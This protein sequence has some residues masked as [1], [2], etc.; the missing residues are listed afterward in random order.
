MRIVTSM[1][2]WVLG[3]VSVVLKILGIS[4]TVFE[5]TK[6]D[7]STSSSSSNDTD[8]D[9]GRFTFNK[10]PIFVPVTTLLLVQ[11]MALAMVILGMQPRARGGHGSGI[12]DVL[13]SAWLVLCLW[14]VLKGLFGKG[15]YGIPL[16]TLCKST[17]LALLFVFWCRRTT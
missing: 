4:E 13:C 12:L 16:S 8:G 17:A 1:S 14:P 3:V 10:S 11:L 7:Q 15:K 9:A 5:V 6:K 2:A